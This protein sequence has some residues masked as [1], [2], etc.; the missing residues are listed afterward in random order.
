MVYSYFLYM[1]Y[2][3]KLT[4]TLSLSQK[5]THRHHHHH[6]SS[7]TPPPPPTT[8]HPKQLSP[9]HKSFFNVVLGECLHACGSELAVRAKLQTCKVRAPRR[10]ED[11]HVVVDAHGFVVA[12]Q[13]E[14]C[15]RVKS[16]EQWL[17]SGDTGGFG[18]RSW[19]TVG[20]RWSTS[21]CWQSGWVVVQGGRLKRRTWW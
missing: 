2:T 13:S 6:P 10:G 3:V 18:L 17:R 20:T 19:A 9:L 16:W 7:P 11:E 21:C 15:D 4:Q 5:H 12:L 1:W 8:T 14:L